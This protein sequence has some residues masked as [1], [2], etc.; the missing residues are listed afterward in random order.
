M[1]TLFNPAISS[2]VISF[3]VCDFQF[4][5]GKLNLLGLQLLLNGLFAHA[6]TYGHV[7]KHLVYTFP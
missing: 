6:H 5:V 1:G 3:I 4:Y 2:F 7:H